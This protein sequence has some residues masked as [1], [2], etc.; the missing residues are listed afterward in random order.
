M[1]LVR[2]FDLQ[3]ACLDTVALG[4][5]GGA[6]VHRHDADAVAATPRLAKL[7]EWTRTVRVLHHHRPGHRTGK[8]ALLVPDEAGRG[9]AGRRDPGSRAAGRVSWSLA[10]GSE[11]AFRDEHAKMVEWLLEPFSAVLENDRRMHELATLREAAEADRRSLLSRLGRSDMSRDD[12]GRR[13]RT[14][15][16]DGACAV[17]VAVGRAGADPG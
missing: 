1:L 4:G 17:G 12:R 5:V 6:T 10:A 11:R 13:R 16:C 14:A 2:R 15:R 7:V 9:A 3:H 8:L